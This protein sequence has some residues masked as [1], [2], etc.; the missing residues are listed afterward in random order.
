L[1][2]KRSDSE[3]S[4]I[5][6]NLKDYQFTSDSLRHSNTIDYDYL[7]K[8]IKLLSNDKKVS[9]V[10]S[11]ILE[12]QNEAPLRIYINYKYGLKAGFLVAPIEKDDPKCQECNEIK[13]N[14]ECDEFSPPIQQDEFVKPEDVPKVSQDMALEFIDI[15]KNNVDMEDFEAVKAKAIANRSRDLVVFMNKFGIETYLIH[16]IERYKENINIHYN[17]FNINS[18]YLKTE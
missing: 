10:E 4:S 3:N 16:C 7:E 9:F 14:C 2:S 17:G 13:Q 12:S 6:L 8:F 18:R 1:I 5:S 11:V 15:E